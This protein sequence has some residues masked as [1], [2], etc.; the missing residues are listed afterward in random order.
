MRL[1]ITIVSAI[2]LIVV[3]SGCKPTPPPTA[4]FTV[5]VSIPFENRDGIYVIPEEFA[6][7][8]IEEKVQS[9]RGGNDA[10]K[11]RIERTFSKRGLNL[12]FRVTCPQNMEEGIKRNINKSFSKNPPH[13]IE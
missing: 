9:V 10:V 8:R 4:E 2:I 11:I 6:D 1:M 12:S 3:W 13:P 7:N 5:K